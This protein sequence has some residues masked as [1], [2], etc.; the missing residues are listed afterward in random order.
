MAQ[1]ETRGC[2]G[3]R[4]KAGPG[5]HWAGC[6]SSMAPRPEARSRGEARYAVSYCQMVVGTLTLTHSL[7]PVYSCRLCSPCRVQTVLSIGTLKWN[8][9]Y[10]TNTSDRG[11]Q[12]LRRVIW[13]PQRA[14][15]SQEEG[16]ASYQKAQNRNV[17]SIERPG[18]CD[19]QIS[20][21]SDSGRRHSTPEIC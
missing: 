11:R 15:E 3:P 16:S 19:P 4:E 12:V 13:R 5:T 17:D 10:L 14:R 1:H 20:K 6:R 18:S 9:P 2:C 21:T 7:Q 8:P